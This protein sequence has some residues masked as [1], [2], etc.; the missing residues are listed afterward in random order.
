MLEKQ[1]PFP[2]LREANAMLRAANALYL[3]EGAQVRPDYY[4]RGINLSSRR[5]L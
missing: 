4:S 2:G 3:F 1:S 5:N